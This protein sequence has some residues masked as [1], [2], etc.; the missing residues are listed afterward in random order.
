MSGGFNIQCMSLVSIGNA[1]PPFLPIFP[2]YPFHLI[3]FV[4]SHY[5]RSS[6][7]LLIPPINSLFLLVPLESL[8]SPHWI[9][10]AM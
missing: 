7:F 5:T 10:G 6:L 8:T 1:F 3:Q 4:S 2:F 9:S